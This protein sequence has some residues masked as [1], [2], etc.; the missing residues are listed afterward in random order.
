MRCFFRALLALAPLLLLS[1]CGYVHFGRLPAAAASGNGDA[2][3]VAY[4]SLSTEH[5]I[6]QQELV[7]ARKEGDALRAALDGRTN[8]AEIGRAHV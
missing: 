2:M 8:P 4:S 1:G 7:L 6:L 5:K 3:G